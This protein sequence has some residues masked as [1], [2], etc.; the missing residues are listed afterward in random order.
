MDSDLWNIVRIYK[1]QLHEKVWL[2]VE[3]EKPRYEYYTFPEI[4]FRIGGIG[5]I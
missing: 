1:S 5:L 2:V 3:N 4:L